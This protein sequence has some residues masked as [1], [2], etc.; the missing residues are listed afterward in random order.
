MGRKDQGVVHLTARKSWWSGQIWAL[1]G[2]TQTAGNYVTD[3][4][5]LFGLPG[6]K[7]PA[8]E[9]IKREGKRR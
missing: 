2:A 5:R 1:C 3:T 7:C 4:W 9:R 6:R 8:C